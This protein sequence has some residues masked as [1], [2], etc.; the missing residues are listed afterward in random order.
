MAHEPGNDGQGRRVSRVTRL[1]WYFCAAVLLLSLPTFSNLIPQ[2]EDSF[3]SSSV[4]VSR[5]ARLD[6]QSAPQESWERRSLQDSP[7]ASF[8]ERSSTQQPESREHFVVPKRT[9]V[10]QGVLQQGVNRRN[11]RPDQ[12]PPLSSASFV[13]SPVRDNRRPFL[14]PQD[15]YVTPD[16]RAF[17]EGYRQA[18]DR[19]FGEMGEFAI[20]I[21]A[22]STNPFE[23]ELKDRTPESPPP[24]SQG[25]SQNPQSPPPPQD[26]KQTTPAPPPSENPPPPGGSGK[27]EP[28]NPP[29]PPDNS[30]PKDSKD[31]SSANPYGFVIMGD[32][33]G[34]PGPDHVF[35]AQRRNETDFALDN[36]FLLRLPSRIDQELRSFDP[37]QRVVVGN[38]NGDLRTDFVLAEPTNL[39]VSLQWYTQDTGGNFR[40]NA[41]GTITEATS[42]K[43]IALLRFA[44]DEEPKLAVVVSGNSNLLIYERR[45]HTIAYVKDLVLPIKPALLVGAP[46]DLILG[47]KVPALVCFNETMS[48]VVTL[49]VRNPGRDVVFFGPSPAF[50]HPGKSL[51]VHL[52]GENGESEILVFEEEGRTTLA[53]KT[54]RGV[55]FVGSF[56]TMRRV[57]LALVG[58]FFDTGHWQLSFVP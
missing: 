49:M 54:S 13:K 34:I 46:Q 31:D 39:G 30:G 28:P 15:R 51:K 41:R 9:S 8:S 10:E 17:Q 5:Q 14:A 11:G 7:A 1:V 58:D 45:G 3:P 29:P 6:S 26:S 20:R 4:W 25:T 12:T 33:P 48:R 21:S 56:D 2:V 35:R 57:P 19:I 42:V 37:S 27:S 23:Q 22:P 32:F 24:S 40:R 38:L 55:T 53:E 43:S 44:P 16:L 18:A 47:R 50:T 52:T 36:S